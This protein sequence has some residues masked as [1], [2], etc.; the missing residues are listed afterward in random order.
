MVALDQAK[1]IKAAICYAALDEVEVWQTLPEASAILA[2]WD[3]FIKAIKKIYP[4]CE[5]TDWYSHV[6]VQ[7]LVQDYGRKEMHS[8]DNLGE[9][10]RT[11]LKISVVLIANKKL[12]EME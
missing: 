5:G 10:T 12:A 11:F 4:G 2:N 9:Y 6:D 3:N 8:Q 7:Y 1:K